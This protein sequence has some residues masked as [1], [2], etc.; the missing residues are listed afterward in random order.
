MMAPR[1]RRRR[2]RR[3][4]HGV[5]GGIVATERDPDT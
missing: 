1:R 3:G 4:S 2:R 5:Q